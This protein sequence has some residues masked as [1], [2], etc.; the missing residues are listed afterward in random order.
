MR[1]LPGL[2]LAGVMIVATACA[3]MPPA[4]PSVDITG[5]W[6]GQWAYENPSV[7]SGD[8]RGTFKQDGANL[9]GRFDVTGPVVNRT[10][11]V[12]GF[13]SGNE[14]RL[15]QPSSGTLT[16]SGNQISGLI[17]GLNVAKITLRRP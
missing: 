8:V 5:S 13:V 7:G 14:V 16:I 12:V 9:S 3:T 6:V 10:A 17:N 11:N 1:I 4:P 15:S 2:L